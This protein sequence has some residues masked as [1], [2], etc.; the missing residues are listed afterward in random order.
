V[1]ANLAAAASSINSVARELGGVFGIAVV[2]RVVSDAYRTTLDRSL[3]H[4]PASLEDPLLH[5]A[6]A[7]FTSAMDL[8]MHLA[9]LVA[10]TGALAGWSMLPRRG[11]RDDLGRV[12]QAT[13]SEELGEEVV[14]GQAGSIR[15]TV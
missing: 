5:A 13:G 14:G 9:A 4:L 12:R 10:L 11:L 15:A 7:S 1:P 2:G 6:K 3:T 8:G